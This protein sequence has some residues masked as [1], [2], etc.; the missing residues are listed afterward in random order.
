MLYLDFTKN[1]FIDDTNL[2][3]NFFYSYCI[4]EALLLFLEYK[5]QKPKH[6]FR[7]TVQAVA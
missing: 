7:F 4:L 3:K 5:V 2:T 6:S 1:L